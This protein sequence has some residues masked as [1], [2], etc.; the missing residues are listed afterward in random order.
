MKLSKGTTTLAVGVTKDRV[1][2]FWDQS[3]CGETAFLHGQSGEDYARHLAARYELEPYIRDFVEFPRWRGKRVLEIGIGLGADHSVLVREG[4]LTYGVDLTHRAVSHTHQRLAHL[5][6]HSNLAVG[7]AENLPYS[8]EAF[9]MVFSWGVLHHS[10]NT[11]QG[12]AEVWRVLKPGGTA[13]IMIYNYRSLVGAMLWIRYA[14]LRLRPWM[15]LRDIYSQ[16]LESPGTKAFTPEEAR[17]MCARFSDVHVEVEL[18]HGDLLSPY[19]GQRHKGL[20]L[21]LARFL[22][23]RTFIRKFMKRRGLFML[24]TALK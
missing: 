24:I 14:F 19:A 20:A 23:P 4:A 13:K 16:F 5:G 11:A 7:D 3:A 8:N 9:D 22:W 2:E 17:A 1:K 10:P 21:S 12:F 18:S 15:P 6:V